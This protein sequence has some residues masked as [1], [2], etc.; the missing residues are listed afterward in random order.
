MSND[1]VGNIVNV[2][3]VEIVNIMYVIARAVIANYV[4]LGVVSYDQR[5]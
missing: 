4:K 3:T 5:A 2:G 1:Q